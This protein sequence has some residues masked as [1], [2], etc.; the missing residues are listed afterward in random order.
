MLAGLR[1]PAAILREKDPISTEA[2]KVLGDITIRIRNVV[3]AVLQVG[4]GLR[5]RSPPTINQLIMTDWNYN[6]KNSRHSYQSYPQR[7]I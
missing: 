2:I 4:E 5:R 6:I 3:T 1:I 7:T